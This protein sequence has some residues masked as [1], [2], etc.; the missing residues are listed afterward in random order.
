[1][2]LDVNRFTVSR[3]NLYEQIADQLEAM[4]L[5]SDIKDEKLPSEQALAEQFAVSRNVIR[6]ALKLLKERGLVE[7]RNGTGSYITKPESEHLSDVM[8]RIIVLD[9]IHYADI[10]NVRTILE[11]AACRKAAEVITDQQLEE[12]EQLLEKLK[13]RSLSVEERREMDFA[14]HLAIAKAAGNPLLEILIQAMK[15][16]F[17]QILEMGIFL[18]G[19]IDDAIL[20]HG[21]I[22]EALKA[23]DVQG[24][25]EAMQDHLE[26][27]RRNVET[28]LNNPNHSS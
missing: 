15:H 18:E 9:N 3:V 23:R 7:S 17:V 13:D 26:Y 28:Y 4:I 24:A 27:S 2:N 25:D 1:M 6:E 5:Q 21:F 12:M 19:G 10:Y 11:T 20:R 16:L 8:G 22:L 14:F